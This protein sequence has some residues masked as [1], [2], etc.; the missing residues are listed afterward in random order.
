[1]HELAE[2]TLLLVVKQRPT[3]AIAVL[4]ISYPHCVRSARYTIADGVPVPGVDAASSLRFRARH[5]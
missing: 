5:G 3:C 4:E 1:M 2:C